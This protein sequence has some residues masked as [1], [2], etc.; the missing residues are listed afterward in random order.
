MKIK[1]ISSINLCIDSAETIHWYTERN[2]QSLPSK[3]VFLV[4]YSHHVILVILEIS[5]EGE[6]LKKKVMR[7]L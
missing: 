7:I 2:Y 4:E 6:M 5:S 3:K 1:M